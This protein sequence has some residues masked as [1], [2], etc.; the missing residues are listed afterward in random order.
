[1]ET[2]A[3]TSASSTTDSV[4]TNGTKS[5][6]RD[7]FLK[8]LIT[9]LRNQDPMKPMEDQAFIAQLAQFSSLEQ[10]Q[11]LNQGLES[12]GQNSAAAQAF[13]LIG[14]T[15]D[16]LDSATSSF[17]TSKVDSVSFVDGQPLLDVGDAQVELSAVVKVY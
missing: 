15:V 1:M 8:L 11:K 16:Y 2:S 17:V 6:D 7:A 3:V 5:L 4:V 9:Q 14:K 12:M 13:A 10:M